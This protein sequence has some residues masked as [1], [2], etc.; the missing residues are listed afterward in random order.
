MK[1][2]RFTIPTP[3]L[4]SRVVDMVNDVP[5]QDRDINGDLYE[6]MLSKIASAGQNGQFLTPRHIIQLMVEMTAPASTDEICDPAA[7]T[8]GFLV[9][10]AEH[11]RRAHPTVMT[12]EQHRPHFHQ[13]MFHGYDFD[14]T[15]LRM[16]GMNMLLRGVEQPDVRY[17]DS[18]SERQWQRGGLV[19]ADP[20]QPTVCR[21]PR[22]RDYV[23]GLAAGRQDE[24]DRAAVPGPASPAAQAWWSCRSHHSRRRVVRV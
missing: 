12:D 10:A 13:S 8:C 15:M 20:R 5:M 7:G 3:A 22:L 17:R 24:E 14:S 6:Y 19:L 1:D 4:L 16:G 9:A 21:Q 2:A 11:V 18:L 23:E